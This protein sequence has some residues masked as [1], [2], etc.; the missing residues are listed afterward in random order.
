MYSI[1][2]YLFFLLSLSFFF[3]SSLN[4]LSC[5]SSLLSSC[6]FSDKLQATVR[7]LAPECDITFL[8]SEDG[9]GKGAAMVTAV[10]QRL[11][12]QS[13]LLEDS[14]GDDEEDEEED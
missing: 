1:V 7:L 14:D 10:A 5:L 9:S 6:S 13:R 3:L 2:K 12:L 11:A 4:I 8:V